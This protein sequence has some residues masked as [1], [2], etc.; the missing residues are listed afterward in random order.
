MVFIGDDKQLAPY[1]SDDIQQLQSVFEFPHLRKR[2]SFLNTQ[3]RMPVVVGDFISRHVY[4]N[5]LKTVHNNNSNTACRFLD[6]KKGQEKKSGHSWVNESEII[7]I[8]HLAGLY[9][10]QGKQ[11]RVVT[12]ASLGRQVL[13][14]NEEDY[15]I[16]SLVR[17]Q[18]VG[19]LKNVRRTNVMLTRCKKS[20]I[21]CTSRQFVTAGKAA[22][23]LVGMLA[24]VMGPEGWLDSRDI[25]RGVLP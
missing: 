15:I 9:Y 12:P 17:S 21:I 1:G 8:A 24:A 7:V 5:Q 6:V 20:M 10:K 4:G 3:Y 18:G 19:F 23:T 16:V 25:A 14:R 11:Y 2:A 13:Q 22:N